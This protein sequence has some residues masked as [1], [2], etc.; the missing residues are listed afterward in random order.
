MRP[1]DDTISDPQ[2]QPPRRSGVPHL[3]SR[4]AAARGTLLRTLNLVLRRVPSGHSINGWRGGR[5]GGGLRGFS[6]LWV[7]TPS[8]ALP[9]LA[10]WR[11][12]PNR[13]PFG[14]CWMRD[15]HSLRSHAPGRIGGVAGQLFVQ[16]EGFVPADRSSRKASHCRPLARARQH[17]GPKCSGGP[18]HLLHWRGGCHPKLLRRRQTRARVSQTVRPPSSAQTAPWRLDHTG[19]PGCR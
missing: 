7:Q 9:L 15:H 16:I 10:C 6:A 19:S 13:C 14:H 5:L 4:Q 8:K 2:A 11:R 3:P 18:W 1:G 17:R 12:T